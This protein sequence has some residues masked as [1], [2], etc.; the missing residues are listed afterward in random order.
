MRSLNRLAASLERSPRLW[1]VDDA[2]PDPHDPSDETEDEDDADA[3]MTDA[4]DVDAPAQDFGGSDSDDSDDGQQ[5]S[6]QDVLACT[7]LGNGLAWPWLITVTRP[8]RCPAGR[9]GL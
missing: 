2:E 8:E 5:I 7:S 3:E 6:I 1:K 9:R 4:G